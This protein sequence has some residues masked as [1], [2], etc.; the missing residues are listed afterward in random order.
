M[1]FNFNFNFNTEWSVVSG[2]KVTKRIEPKKEVTIINSF[3]LKVFYNNIT[4]TIYNINSFYY[5]YK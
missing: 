2:H 3:D 1:D 4:L 5:T